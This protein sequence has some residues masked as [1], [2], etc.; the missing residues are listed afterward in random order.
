MWSIW[1]SYQKPLLLSRIPRNTKLEKERCTFRGVVDS[2]H[3]SSHEQRSYPTFAYIGKNLANYNQKLSN[4]SKQSKLIPKEL[5]YQ[6]KIHAI[7]DIPREKKISCKFSP[8][9]FFFYLL[10]KMQ[11]GNDIIC[12][13]RSNLM[14][15][16]QKNSRST[17]FF[18]LPQQV[19]AML[20]QRIGGTTNWFLDCIVSTQI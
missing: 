4:I 18:C 1:P 7:F 9:K 13:A 19:P 15:P 6:E 5:R 10:K 2:A 3:F 20:S 8:N 16:I 12:K 11:Y 17:C 14:M